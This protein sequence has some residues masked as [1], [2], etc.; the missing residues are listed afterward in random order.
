M[1]VINWTMVVR[2]GSWTE[3]ELVVALAVVCSAAREQEKERQMARRV[4]RAG[5]RGALDAAG[6]ARASTARGQR[7]QASGDGWRHAASPF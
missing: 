1:A 2:R 5:T 7:A 6:R 4:R 3:A